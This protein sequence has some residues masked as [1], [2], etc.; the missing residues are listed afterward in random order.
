MAGDDVNINHRTAQLLEHLDHRALAR[1]DA[2]CEAHQKHLPREEE[3]SENAE[4][5]AGESPELGPA[6]LVGM[7]HT[8]LPGDDSRR[9]DECP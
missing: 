1:G 5:G 3:A 2:P 7:A 6:W 8:D 4:P 9:P